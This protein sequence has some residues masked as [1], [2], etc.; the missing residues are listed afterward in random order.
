MSI[1][2]DKLFCA[3]PWNHFFVQ[4]DGDV[5]VCCMVG[6]QGEVLGN[7]NEQTWQEIW[8]GEKYQDLRRRFLEKDPETLKQC[9]HCLDYDKFGA[10]SCRHQFNGFVKNT[11]H[12]VDFLTRFPRIQSL[13]LR[14]SR[15]CGLACLICGPWNSTRWESELNAKNRCNVTEQGMENVKQLIED[16]KRN[17]IHV[18]IVGG[19]PFMMEEAFYLINKLQPYKK[20]IKI[21]INTNCQ[22][23]KYK[24][25]DVLPLLEGFEYIQIDASLDAIGKAAEYQRYG[26]KWEV[27]QAN[28]EKLLES[29]F[30][31]WVHPTISI[32][33]I[34]R[35]VD[36][37]KYLETL[38]TSKF[39][40]CGGNILFEPKEYDIR[41]LPREIKQ[42][43]E[44]TLLE[45]Q[46]GLKLE[47]NKKLVDGWIETMKSVESGNLFDSTIKKIEEND[48]RRNN[49]FLE[50]NPEFKPYW[51]K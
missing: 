15:T 27:I 36:L 50:V 26:G 5:R 22:T 14:T 25:Q 29:P 11:E 18:N 46:K 35:I 16:Q 3:A 49:S 13:D 45:Q 21:L 17:I 8:E 1:V 20:R 38:D 33:N 23:L 9:Q 24:G 42:M 10:G 31:I 43:I 4:Q 32:F 51:K 7:I 19:E 40:I 47:S 44:D 34:L 12:G 6:G 30:K 41:Y 28:F 48:M 2:E 39:E 37:L